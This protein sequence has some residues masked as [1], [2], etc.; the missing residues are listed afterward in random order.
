ML[1][2]P[3]LGVSGVLGHLYRVEVHVHCFFPVMK[4][5][6][7]HLAPWDVSDH[8]EHDRLEIQ[9]E[10][11]WSKDYM[12]FDLSLD[13]QLCSKC[14]FDTWNVEKDELCLG[15]RFLVEGEWI[16]LQHHIVYTHL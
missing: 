2:D 16:F 15:T 3:P 1:E 8:S 5:C 14:L 6:M 13:F 9:C 10:R 11:R 7:S 4:K 12:L